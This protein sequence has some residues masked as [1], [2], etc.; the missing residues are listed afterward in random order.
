MNTSINGKGRK[1]LREKNS[2]YLTLFPFQ[3]RYNLV[4]VLLEPAVGSGRGGVTAMSDLEREEKE[5]W[6]QNFFLPLHIFLYF[7]S[8]QPSCDHIKN[9]IKIILSPESYDLSV[10]SRDWRKQMWSRSFLFSLLSLSPVFFFLFS[11]LRS[12]FPHGHPLLLK[13]KKTRRPCLVSKFLTI[14]ILGHSL[15][16]SL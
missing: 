4:V 8:K 13:G 1:K 9:K 15:S 7:F 14:S 2:K 16:F 10:S 5:I 12:S 11:L 3:T 6:L